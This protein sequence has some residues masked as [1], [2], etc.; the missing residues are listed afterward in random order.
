[1]VP[2]DDLLLG[3]HILLLLAFIGVT[4]ML[5]LVTV[6]NRLRVRDVLLSWPSGSLFGLPL[7]SSLFLVVVFVFFAISA[8][9]EQLLYPMIFAG[10]LMGG[11]FWF[12]A[13]ILMSTVHI[14]PHGLILNVNRNGRAISWGQI[15]DY[16]EFEGSGKSGVVF[17]Y[18]D[19]SGSRRRFELVVPRV[20]EQ[21]FRQIVRAR[22]SGRFKLQEHE[23]AGRQTHEE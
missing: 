7:A 14:T 12:A 1:M 17:F 16:F 21:R 6:I 13:S 5:M 2:V 22:L 15:V 4:S 9:E 20:C 18:T 10:Y 23:P 19:G 3:V 8:L 11:T